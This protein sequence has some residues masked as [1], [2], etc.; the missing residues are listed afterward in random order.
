MATRPQTIKCSPRTHSQSRTIIPSG[1]EEQQVGS[2]RTQ[3]RH[4]SG[5]T[6]SVLLVVGGGAVDGVWSTQGRKTALRSAGKQ[7][8]AFTYSQL[9]MQELSLSSFNNHIQTQALH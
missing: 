7:F 1:H 4:V 5:Q 3:L 2:S 6:G 9:S 8:F